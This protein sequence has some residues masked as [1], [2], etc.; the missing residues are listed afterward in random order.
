MSEPR[1]RSFWGWGWEDKFPDAQTRRATGEHAKLL[2]GFGPERCDEPPTLDSITLAA[3]R[4]EVPRALRGFVTDDHEA[5]IRHTYGKNYRDVMR[6]F[7]GDFANA[8]DLVAHPTSERDIE[9][10]LDWASGAGVAVIPYGGGTSVAGGV[11][12]EQADGQG[13]VLSL[14]LRGLDKVLEVERSSMSARIQ[15][16]ATGPV[17]ETQLAQHGLTLRHFPQSF[18]FSTLGGWIATRA[19]GHFATLY[20]HIDDLVQSSRML[21]PRGVFESRRLPGSGAGPS[22]DR[23]VLGSEGT[24]GVITEAW[25]RVRPR[26]IYRAT[27][28]A[29]FR[30]YANAVEGVR[31]LSQSGLYPTNCRLLDKREA[32]LNGVTG[33]GSHVLIVAF[34]SADHSQRGSMA[35]ALELVHDHGGKVPIGAQFQEPGEERGASEAGGAATWRDA[36][37]DAP[38]ILNTMASMGVVVDTFET[39]CTWDNFERLHAGVLREVRQAMKEVCGRGFLSCRFTHV[40]PDG[41]APYFTFVAPGRPGHEV[42]Q[43]SAIKEAASRAVVDHGGTITHHHAV[44]RVHRPGYEVQRP[45]PF[46]DV[47]R[48]VKQSLD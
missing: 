28:T 16:G 24:L 14:D 12:I 48:A 13:G 6:A 41:P 1:T 31:A 22:P 44:G 47:L 39:A 18:E 29:H 45:A 3:P 15:A 30:D 36:F 10:A 11:E 33:D 34:E 5:R 46:G 26:P 20:T 17:L 32:A 37:I 4:V 19:G 43:W 7:R 9:M 40:Y 42:E 2:L 8:P 25:V 27:A 21:T 38:Y 23:L 35:R